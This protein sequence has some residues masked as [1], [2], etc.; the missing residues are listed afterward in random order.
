LIKKIQLYKK[1][2]I[3]FMALNVFSMALGLVFTAQYFT[4]QKKIQS[5]SNQITQQYQIINQVE[6]LYSI[7]K[8]EELFIPNSKM[9]IKLNQYFSKDYKQDDFN[10]KYQAYF[11][12]LEPNLKVYDWEKLKVFNE[13]YKLQIL[14]RQTA[15]VT[16][17]SQTQKNWI[18]IGL[19]TL[20]F[21][22]I[23]PI[24]LLSLISRLI[25]KVQKALYAKTTDWLKDLRQEKWKNKKAFQSPE[26]W[27]KVSLI[28]IE[29]WAKYGQH[30]VLQFSSEL[31]GIIKDELNKIEQQKQTHSDESPSEKTAA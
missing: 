18:S 31:S 1:L 3:V 10:K 16:L 4:S 19:L 28:S 27:M 17:S 21:G 22:I 5:E 24:T 29:H 20:I 25:Y 23:L 8:P 12:R 2:L 26:F 14:E 15:L 9:Y 7:K 13:S 30:P 6:K 11:K